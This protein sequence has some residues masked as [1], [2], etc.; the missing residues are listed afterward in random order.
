MPKKN[1]K[2]QKKDNLIPKILTWVLIIGGI[3]GFACA[4]V[5]TQDKIHLLANPNYRPSCDLNPVVACSNVM[6]SKQSTAFGF[7]NPYIGLATFP[8]LTTIGLALLAGAKF[9]RWFWVGLE[10]G[11]VFGFGFIH[12]LFFESVYRIHSLCPYCMVVWVITMTTFL[13]VTINN[14]EQGYI[15]LPKYHDQITGFLRRHHLD[16]LLLWA[17]VIFALIMHHFWY[18]YG[19]HL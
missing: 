19:K 10:A 1:E 7:S 16:L 17:L 18:Y 8:I 9:K 14:L 3:I 4:V 11:A 6:Q 13:Y 15:K 12:W 2:N 5:I